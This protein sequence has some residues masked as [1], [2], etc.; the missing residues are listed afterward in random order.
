MINPPT[1]NLYKFSAISG[2]ILLIFGTY[3][4]SQILMQAQKNQI[5]LDSEIEKYKL[6]I[7]DNKIYINEGVLLAEEKL[8]YYKK[9]INDLKTLENNNKSKNIK[10]YSEKYLNKIRLTSE[11]TLKMVDS[12]KKVKSL[13]QLES[14][15][16]M[17]ELKKGVEL[18]KLENEN[19]V[20][21]FRYQIFS[22]LLGVFFIFF[23]FKKWYIIQMRLDKSSEVN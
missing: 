7:E 6:K 15:I 19:V 8:N 17:V 3:Y 2:L 13:K 12:I 23:G 22:Q 4:P 11:K 5:E 10:Y 18:L 16:K 1:D 9:L 21:Y 14:S 20:R